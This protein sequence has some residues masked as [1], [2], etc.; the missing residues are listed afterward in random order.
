MLDT[1]IPRSRLERHLNKLALSIL[2]PLGFVSHEGGCLRKFDGAEQYFAISAT[3]IGGINAV[4]PFGQTGLLQPFLISQA[5]LGPVR[6]AGQFQVDYPYFSGIPFKGRPCQTPADLPA[7]EVW[8][9]DFLLRQ[10][11]PCLEEYSKPLA[12]LRAYLDHDETQKNTSDVLVWHGW[13]SAAT[14]LI[15]ARLYG[16]EHYPGLRQRYARIFEP[17]LPEYKDRVTSLLKYLDKRQLEALPEAG[18]SD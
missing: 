17:L 9:R 14:G 5:F 10:M 16:T 11:L 15:Y 4:T 8:L 7:T 12:I 13:A 18:T 1:K 2:Q 6:M 3:D